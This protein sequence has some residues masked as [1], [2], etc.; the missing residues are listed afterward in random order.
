MQQHLVKTH[1]LY[2]QALEIKVGAY[3]IM[4]VLRRQ[5]N[6]FLKIVLIVISQI[7]TCS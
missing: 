5:V 1:I 7:A 2:I 3:Q 4:L 6:L